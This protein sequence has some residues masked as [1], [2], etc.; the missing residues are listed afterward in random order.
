M[1]VTVFVEGGG[2]RE[3]LRTEC[4]KGFRLFFERAGLKGRMPTIK[5]RG[6]RG[7]AFDGFQTALSIAKSK[8]FVIL[9]VDSEA[10]V[11]T[12][13]ATQNQ[14]SPWLHLTRRDGWTKPVSATDDHAHL[15]VQCMETWFLADPDCLKAYFEPGLKADK[16]KPHPRLEDVNKSTVFKELAD[17]TAAL[18]TKSKYDERSKGTHSFEILARLDPAKV[19]KACPHAD[20]LLKTLGSRC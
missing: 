12:D 16:L 18:K 10:P 2:D 1:S 6:S 7:S 20:R 8:E 14:V 4:R 19:R 3:D 5:A 13:P 17:A 11:E 9:L 15:M